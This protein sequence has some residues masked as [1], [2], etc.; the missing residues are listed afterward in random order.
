[1]KI[2]E[3]AFL[4]IVL[5][6]LS[7]LLWGLAKEVLA[8]DS[9]CQ[10]IPP[11]PKTVYITKTVEAKAV[12]SNTAA[13]ASATATNSA[14]TGNQ[15][16]NV[17]QP[18]QKPVVVKLKRTITK[19]RTKTVQKKVLVYKPN[20]LLLLGGATKTRLDIDFDCCNLDVKRRYEPD[21][22]LQYLRDFGT[23]SAGISATANRSV[24]L[25]LGIN[26]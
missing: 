18:Q 10:P 11:K 3:Q 21:F 6:F 2:F 20:R 17:I 25:N 26:W 22:G 7:I 8:C 19:H 1:M 12:P 13:T 14:T 16:V 4:F 9:G 5:L 23:M 15:V 24:Y